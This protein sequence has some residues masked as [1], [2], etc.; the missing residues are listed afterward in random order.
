MIIDLKTHKLL[1]KAIRCR[2]EGYKMKVASLENDPWESERQT[3]ERGKKKTKAGDPFAGGKSFTINFNAVPDKDWCYPLPGAKVISPYGRRGGRMH[4]GTDL[5]TVPNDPIYAA[6]DGEVTMSQPYSGYGK[7]III[8][9]DN[10]LETL[11]SHNSKNLVEVG[12]HVK[13]GQKIAL[14]GRT[15]RATTEHLHFEVRVAGRHYN[16][17]IL[18]DHA[19]H[20]LKKESITFYKNGRQPSVNGKTKS[21]AT[22]K[23]SSIK[24][25]KKKSSRRTKSKSKRRRRR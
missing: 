21:S 11:Y 5:K 17:N 6:F 14:T 16:P 22:K 25:S 2:R 19:N 12:N 10:G 1:E 13:A 9:H 23:K 7:C 24:K 3:V 4:T 15:G 20:Q 8:R 18:F